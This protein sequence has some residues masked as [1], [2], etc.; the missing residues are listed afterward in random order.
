M[1][2]LDEVQTAVIDLAQ[3]TN[4]YATIEIGALPADNGICMTYSSGS[5]DSTFM[6]KGSA[7]SMDMVC[8]GKHTDQEILINTL[9]AIHEALTQATDYPTAEGWQITNIITTAAPT[10]I[11]RQPNDWYMYGSSLRVN[12]YYRRANNA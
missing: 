8:N 1:S 3:D 9:A 10:Y 6:D 4:P 12:F 2:V 5:P 7:Y 11:D